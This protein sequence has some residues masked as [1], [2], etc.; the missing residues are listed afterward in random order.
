VQE[1]IYDVSGDETESD[2][3][4]TRLTG[5][6]QVS[7]QFLPVA[8][9]PVVQTPRPSFSAEDTYR[10]SWNVDTPMSASGPCTPVFP[11]DDVKMHRTAST[12]NSS[13]DHS[14]HG[15]HIG[16]EGLDMK[17]QAR[18]MSEHGNMQPYNMVT[19]SQPMQYPSAPAV[20]NGQTYQP[21][22]QYSNSAPS[23]YA[24]PAPTFVNPFS[25]YAAPSAIGYGQ[26]VPPMPTNNGFAYD[27]NM[28]PPTPVSYASSPMDMQMASSGPPMAFNGL[29]SEYSTNPSGLPHY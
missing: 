20:F 28:F 15:L 6:T 8:A 17:P 24:Q 29:P 12:P 1:S 14:L 18:T 9:L 25:M 2:D 16:E 11:Q 4:M 21:T 22:E 13:F 26:Y 7:P 5:I 27:Q 3:T 19:Y 10:H 23:P